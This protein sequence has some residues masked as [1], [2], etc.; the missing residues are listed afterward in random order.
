MFSSLWHTF[1]YNPIYNGLVFFIDVVPTADVGIAIILVTIVVKLIVFPLSKK[2]TRTQMIMKRIQPELNKLKEK[3]KDDRQ[4]QAEKMME[5]YREN[6]IN[7]LS[8]LGLILIQLPLIFALYWIFFKGGLP[9]I[10]T[11]ILY[12]FIPVPDL[13]NMEFIGLVDMAGRSMILAAAAGITQYYQISLTLPKIAEKKDNA[14]LKEDLARSFQLQMKYVMPAFVFMV[15]Y[16]ISAAVALYW[17]TSNIFA[18]G[19]EFVIRKQ[20]KEK[21]KEE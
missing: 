21:F 3:Y 9:E 4:K 14:T 18:I 16:F 7:P 8:G 12:P 5:I 17:L 10:N 20:V 2:A 15:A 19:Q 11:L 6:D 1:F 13:V